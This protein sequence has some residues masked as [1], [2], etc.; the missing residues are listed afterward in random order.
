MKNTRV[1]FTHVGPVTVADLLDKEI[2]KFEETATDEVAQAL[3]AAVEENV[4]VRL[5]VNFDHV[6]Y[7]NSCMLG[8]LIRLKKRIKEQGGDLKLCSLSHALYEMF[9]F[10]EVYKLFDIHQNAQSALNSFNT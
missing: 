3:F 2:S 4:P 6:D 1:K 9:L 8:V 10:T 7:L 5:L